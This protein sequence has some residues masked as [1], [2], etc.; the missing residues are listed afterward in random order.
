MAVRFTTDFHYTDRRSKARYVWLKYGEILR[1][2][3][4]L[5]V[6]ADDCHLRENLDESAT[7]WGIGK[8]GDSDQEFDLESGELP[9]AD[10]SY[11]CVLCLD[12]LEHLE[13]A[14]AI[15]H[16]L[17]RVSRRHVVVSLPNPW[18]VFWHVLRARDY[19]P[20]RPL[21]FYGLPPERPQDRH[22]WFFS[23]REAREFIEHG[24]AKC[25]MQILQ[26]DNE[27]DTLRR[28]GWK[29][30]W[31]MSILLRPDVDIES[32]YVGPLWAVLEKP[33]A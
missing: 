1:G 11:D 25:G 17:C 14:H 30:R 33:G 6:G 26:M 4:I 31:A 10:G 27:S 32:L 5:D 21:K 20:G 3:R 8:G 24:A 19:R 15:F 16:E 7:Y 9:F 23:Q 18:A 2:R 22:R 29:Q 13:S 28:F 12:V